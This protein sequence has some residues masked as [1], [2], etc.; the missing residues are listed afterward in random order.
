MTVT[1]WSADEERDIAVEFT[2]E[3]HAALT[4]FVQKQARKGRFFTPQK[5]AR[6]MPSPYNGDNDTFDTSSIVQAFLPDGFAVEQH[7]FEDFC[8]VSV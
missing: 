3:E 8:I 1:I 5:V 2:D 6:L 4:A 7:G